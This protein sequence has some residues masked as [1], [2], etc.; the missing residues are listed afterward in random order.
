M[1]FLF[2][3]LELFRIFSIYLGIY[4]LYC[5]CFFIFLGVKFNYLIIGMCGVWILWMLVIN[6]L[7]N[8]ISYSMY[9]G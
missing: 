4:Y 9:I 6:N 3:D 5:R 2:C 1:F 8:M 7:Y